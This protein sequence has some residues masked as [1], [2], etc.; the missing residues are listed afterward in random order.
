MNFRPRERQ[1]E[2]WIG[3]VGAQRFVQRD[4]PPPG[5]IMAFDAARGTTTMLAEELDGNEY[6]AW[7]PSGLLVSGRSLQLG[8]AVP[9][10][11]L[12]S[13][14]ANVLTILAGPIVFNE[15]VPDDP[16]GMVLRILAFVLVIGAAALTPPPVRAVE[17]A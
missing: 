13:T 5:R 11:A 1:D 4:G 2:Q 6:H 7:T 16:A 17:P 9:V 12:T 3:G 10:I 15:P 8:D 14:T